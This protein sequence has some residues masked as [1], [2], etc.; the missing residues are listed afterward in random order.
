MPKLHLALRC[1]VLLLGIS[2]YA[3]GKT[4][5]ATPKTPQGAVEAFYEWRIRSQMTGAPD[6]DQLAQMSPY[7]TEELRALLATARPTA[8]DISKKPAKRKGGRNKRAFAEGDLFS[9]LFDGPTSFTMDK[10]EV[11]THG[12][13]HVVPVRLTSAKQL[14]AVNWVDKVKVVNEGDRY[15]VAD[16]EYG[17]HWEFGANATLMGTLKSA[18]KRRVAQNVRPKT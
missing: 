14:P 5:V 8:G 6:Q 12:N 7:I 16:I 9:S 4:S 11:E 15:L 18:A 13:E 17:S 1:C 2:L 3:C 10:D